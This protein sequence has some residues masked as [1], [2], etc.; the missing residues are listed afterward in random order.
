MKRKIKTNEVKQYKTQ[1]K[2]KK[3]GMNVNRHAIVG[4][5]SRSK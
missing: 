1:S 3:N 4:D 5:R 2:L